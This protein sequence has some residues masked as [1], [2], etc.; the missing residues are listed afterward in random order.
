MV[1]NIEGK[2]ISRQLPKRSPALFSLTISVSE[3][4]NS[5]LVRYEYRE[6]SAVPIYEYDCLKCRKRFDVFCAR[7]G[8]E[9]AGEK[10]PDCGSRRTRKALSLFGMSVRG[11][12]NQPGS[13][14]SKGRSCAGCAATSCATCR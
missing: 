10:C 1:D 6:K 13:S 9:S 11:S 8:G 4:S 12:S 7:V 5:L 14:G 3:P 2:S